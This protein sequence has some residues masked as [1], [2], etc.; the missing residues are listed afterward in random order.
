MDAPRPTLA[1]GAVLLDAAGR[2]LVVRR[3]HPPAA[4]RWSLPGGRVEPG[5]SLTE[6]VAR[7]VAEETGLEVRV[8]GLVGHLE[9]RDP[10]HH[11]VIL[12]FHAEVVDGGE[13]R[14]GDDADDVAW[15]TRGELEA[16]GPTDDLLDFLDRHGVGIAT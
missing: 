4:G 14:A 9:I 12:D 8:G 11:L 5:E 15:M 10:E 6:A 3:G 7:E 1:V 13:P 2:L 16:A